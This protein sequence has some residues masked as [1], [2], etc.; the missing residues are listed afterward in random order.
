VKIQDD[1]EITNEKTTNTLKR[2]IHYL[3]ALQT[4]N[5]YWPAQFS[6]PLFPTALFVSS[7]YSKYIVY[8]KIIFKLV[9]K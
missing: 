3:S 5:G 1:E 2:A 8:N 7:T 9:I 6:G 4:S